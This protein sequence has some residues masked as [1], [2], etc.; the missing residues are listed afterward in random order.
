MEIK[1]GDIIFV[2]KKGKDAGSWIWK[3]FYFLQK[4]ITRSRYTHCAIVDFPIGD[5][6]VCFSAETIVNA[7]PLLNYLQLQESD[8][9]I[10]SVNE[11]YKD[12]IDNA[13][14]YLNRTYLGTTYGFLQLFWFF[15]RFLMEDILCFDVKKN[16]NWFNSGLICSESV[17]EYLLMVFSEN[18]FMKMQLSHLTK[19]T[20]HVRDIYSM[21]DS[22]ISSELKM[23]KVLYLKQDGKIIID[24][25]T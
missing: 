20:C 13:L 19:D 11:F 12:K 1:T 17:Y 9:I 6:S 2:N 23:F 14:G 3:V 15:Y 22:S 25:I 24:E 4:L 16:Q 8:M 18:R 5:E 7:R 10:Y 21:I